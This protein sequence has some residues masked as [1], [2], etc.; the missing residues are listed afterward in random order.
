M[1]MDVAWVLVSDP[2]EIVPSLREAVFISI[3]TRNMR[4]VRRV[5]PSD[6]ESA[7]FYA[8]SHM[9]RQQFQVYFEFKQFSKQ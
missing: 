7:N 4:S 8:I 1:I 2:W 5:I 6:T 9:D 3:I